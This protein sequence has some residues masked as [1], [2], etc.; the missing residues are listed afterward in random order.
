MSRSAAAAVAL[1][2]VAVLAGC[3]S[4]KPTQTSPKP[5]SA[6]ASGTPA[7]SSAPANPSQLDQV[8]LELTQVATFAS[9]VGFAIR[10]GD[11]SLYIAEQDGKVRALQG[12]STRDVLDLTRLT[13]ASGEQ[14]LLGLAFAP[15]GTHLYVDYTDNKGDSNVDE[16]AVASDGTVD[17]ATRRRVLFQDQPYA[18]HN[19]GNLVFGPDGMLYIGFGDGGS[20][21]DPDRRALDTKTWLGKILRIDPTPSAGKSYTVPA[22]NPFVG[23]AD[24][25]P[26]IWSLGLRNP[27]RFSFDP[28]NGDVWIGDV[29]QGSIEEID[30]VPAA[31][32]A[33][34]GTNFGWSA[35]EGTHRFNQDQSAPGSW[36]PIYEYEHGPGCSVTG[37]VVY[38]GSAIPALTGAYLF[39]DYCAGGVNALIASGQTLVIQKRL[40]DAPPTV[41]SFGVGPNGEVYVLSLG[42]GLFRID[43]G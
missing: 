42:G 38:R 21:G 36:M 19:G 28:A 18:N 29:G 22:D 31:Q 20:G 39:S 11:P 15:D 32:G 33:G 1:T 13:N 37:G 9:P 24:Y 25:L 8:K 10:T 7:S 5:T 3:V 41:S 17:P 40:S 12:S 30:V 2:V 6:P 35:Y 34:K 43:Q 14:G 16:Y 23:N 27:W 4:S 26:E